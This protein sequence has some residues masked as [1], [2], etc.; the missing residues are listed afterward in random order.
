LARSPIE[1]S[2]AH[3][4]LGLVESS[5]YPSWA[6]G[7]AW[8]RWAQQHPDVDPLSRC[9]NR[10]N[11]S[12][13][14]APGE[15]GERTRERQALEL[16]IAGN[17]GRYIKDPA[18]SPLILAVINADWPGVAE[19]IL[20]KYPNPSEAELA[21]A[22]EL[23]KPLVSDPS[24]NWVSC[25]W[26]VDLAQ[27]VAVCEAIL[28]LYCA[29]A[30]REG[31]VM[32]LLGVAV[33]G[34]TGARAAWRQVFWRSL[35][36]W[37]PVIINIGIVCCFFWRAAFP[38]LVDNNPNSLLAADRIRAATYIVFTPPAVFVA[39]GACSVLLP[40]RGLQD[41]LAGTYLV[42]R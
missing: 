37:S 19:Q 20:D 33:V 21:E 38:F 35:V 24:L 12:E 41:R 6:L 31:P 23:V 9:L 7:P 13:F 42:P 4:R 3:N 11:V 18:V 1:L 34:R 36:V 30:F 39:L 25:V 26:V 15:A 27:V 22:A 40:Q 28:S 8:E 10:I 29:L 32:R 16:Y 17:L 5:G 2:S 14:P